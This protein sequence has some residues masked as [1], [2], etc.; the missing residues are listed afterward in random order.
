[1]TRRVAVLAVA[2]LL[3]SG[4]LAAAAA[5]WGWGVGEGNM[6]VRF[7]PAS[8]PDRGFTFCKLMYDQV[9][10]EALGMGWSTDYPYAGINLMHRIEGPDDGRDQQG[11]TGRSQPL[12]RA[13]DRRRA[14]QLPVRDGGRRGHDRDERGGGVAAAG[15]PAQGRLPLGGRLLGTAR[16]G[17]LGRRNLPRAAAVAVSH[18]GRAARSS[19]VPRPDPRREGAADHVDPVLVPVARADDVRARTRQRRGP[20]PGDQRRARPGSWW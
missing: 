4:M 16:L 12:G 2:S 8:M 3:L 10:Y 18:P 14:V 15:V 19:R 9:R 7:P 11:S 5:Q 20:F 17:P 6:P 1:M 13:A